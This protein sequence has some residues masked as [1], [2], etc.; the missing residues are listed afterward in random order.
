MSLV[1]SSIG[2]RLRKGFLIALTLSSVIT[3]SGLYLV[4]R[5][6]RNGTFE[7]A[8]QDDM[9]TI[10]SITQ[11]HPNSE[12]YVNVDPKL[13]TDYLAGGN[14]FFQMWDASSLYFTDKSPSLEALSYRFAHPG[15]ASRTAQRL[16]VTLP[17]GRAVSL[18]WQRSNAQWAV[19]PEVLE[20]AGLQISDREVDLLVGRVRTELDESLWP[21]AIACAGGALLM[22]LIAAAILALLLPRA[23]RP[24]LELTRAIEHREPDNIEP[25]DASAT[26]EVQ[27]I[28]E[29]LNGLLHRIASVRKRERSFLV[30]TAHEL[31]TPLAELQVVAD[32][33]LLSP[34]DAHQQ[35]Q[36][37][38]Q[39][40]E[41]T[42][43]MARLVDALFRLARRE[44]KLDVQ[45]TAIALATL[46][47]AALHAVQTA[48]NQRGLRWHHQLAE[49][50][51]VATDPVLLRA[52]LDNLLGNVVAHARAHT[53]VHLHWHAGE[54][55]GGALD[56]RNQFETQHTGPDD[57]DRMGHGLGIAQLYAHALA[58]QLR[59]EK[60]APHFEVTLTFAAH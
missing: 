47:H 22:P 51:M 31:R 54:G 43:R 34:G 37:M 60:T 49:N 36:T 23:L 32:V 24:L 42:R 39:I 53:D 30:D 48:G 8:L 55:G 9:R 14:R 45:H 41:V 27:R 12:L 10:A 16:E 59:T 3:F 40:S 1:R 35:R 57:L 29:R 58:L 25:F 44:R 38:Q 15:P 46:V 5:T 33:A 18:V 11:V 21:L 6:Q 19:S 28:T 20:S 50:V 56:I 2:S 52:L 13:L 7:Q 26:H 17:D 4:G